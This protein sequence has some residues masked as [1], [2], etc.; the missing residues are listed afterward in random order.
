[1]NDL[2]EIFTNTELKEYILE[3]LASAGIAENEIGFRI[4]FGHERCNHVQSYV[5]YENGKY[6]YRYLGIRESECF[7]CTYDTKEEL[8]KQ[9][10]EEIAVVKFCNGKI[11]KKCEEY[12]LELALQIDD[13]VVELLKKN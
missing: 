12:A 11:A 10:I 8:L 2:R 3:K 9:V 7:S 13:K 1:M 4:H 5:Y 6:C